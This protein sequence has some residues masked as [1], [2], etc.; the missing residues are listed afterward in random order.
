[1]ARLWTQ[2]REPQYDALLL[3]GAWT[4]GS[5]YV[6]WPD[7][8]ASFEMPQLPSGDEVLGTAR[9]C[10]PLNVKSVLARK[11]CRTAYPHPFRNAMIATKFSVAFI[12]AVGI[13]TLFAG[14][15]SSS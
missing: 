6:D 2:S 7:R 1:M 11:L 12:V 4:V 5:E 14:I 10:N 13:K 3:C 9:V 15:D 8:K